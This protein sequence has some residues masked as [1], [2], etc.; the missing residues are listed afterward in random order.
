M[1]SL[2]VTIMCNVYR[3]ESKFTQMI[4]IRAAQNALDT[5]YIHR[6]THKGAHTF[7]KIDKIK[8]MTLFM[9]LE[10]LYSCI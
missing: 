8:T 1:C 4:E 7:D 10:W 2:V 5:G 9:W 3:R 6:H